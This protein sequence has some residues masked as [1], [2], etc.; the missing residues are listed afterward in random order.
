MLVIYLF[1]FPCWTIVEFEWNSIM[2]F[3]VYSEGVGYSIVKLP[4]T[5]H[6]RIRRG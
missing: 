5:T 1:F 2:Y 4:V 3:V 6:A